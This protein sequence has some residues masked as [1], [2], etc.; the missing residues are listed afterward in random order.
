MVT[1][2]EPNSNDHSEK[3]AKV[4]GN[5]LMLTTNESLVL[6]QLEAFSLFSP[7]PASIRVAEG[8]PL[9][10]K[11]DELAAA[12][13]GHSK[14]HFDENAIYSQQFDT[15]VDAAVSEIVTAFMRARTSI[16]RTHLY[17]IGSSLIK[18]HPELMDLPSEPNIRRILIQQVEHS[19]W[20]HAE[21]SYLRLAS[22][23]DRLGQLLDFAF[24]NIR[25]YE[26]DGFSDVLDRV[27]TNFVPMNSTL[28]DSP[29]WTRLRKFQTSEQ[30]DGLKWLLRRRNLLVHSLHLSPS[31]ESQDSPIFIE[32]YN[33]LEEAIREKLRPGTPDWELNQ[34]HQ[35]LR[36]AASLFPDAVDLALLGVS[37]LRRA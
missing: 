26:R 21:A 27:R 32:A 17:L 4:L 20:E 7:M 5:V 33:H 30:E 35:H 3:L 28:R 22:F 11:L 37:G 10:A 1:M 14:L 23:W 36:Q 19:F 13:G 8:T 15:Y 31:F 16:C 6:A 2:N 29:A 9:E 18:Q 34:G 12:L 25:Q 24:F